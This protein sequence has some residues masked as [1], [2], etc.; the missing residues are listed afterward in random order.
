MS[1]LFSDFESVSAKQ[2]K[3]KIQYDLKGSDYNDTLVWQSLEG[4]HVAPTYHSDDFETFQPIIGTP[5][6]WNITQDIFIDD[7]IIANNLIHN[8][9]DKGAESVIL[10]AE[11]TFDIEKTFAKFPFG[12]IPIYLNFRFLD[13]DFLM[14]LSKF[15]SEKSATVFYNLDI[16]GNLAETGN[17]FINEDSDYA[18]LDNF[19]AKSKSKNIKTVVSVNV[20]LYQNAGA[21]MVQQLA[22][23]ICHANEYLNRL[24]T[25][26]DSGNISAEN[27][28]N[29]TINFDFAIGPNYFFEIAKI[30]ALR[31][32][33][34]ALAE[35]YN[36][37]PECHILARPSKR[38]KTIYDYNINMLR[39]TTECMSAALGGANAICNL[40]YDAL[41]HKSNDFGERIARNQ[42]IILKKES[43]FDTVTNAADGS[44]YIENLTTQLAEKAL[45]LFKD[46]EKSGGLLVQLKEGTIQK[47]IK[48]SAKKEQQFF[49]DGK[50]KLVGTNYHINETDLMKNDLQLY[51]FVKKNSRKTLIFPIVENRLAEK[52]EQERLKIEL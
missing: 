45:I 6:K 15:L 7:E 33:Y 44:Y 8:A 48:E 37:N 46:I 16:I 18:I 10:S 34:A 52:T 27:R 41:Y 21:N 42:L 3:Q 19:L 9:I 43:Y 40:P 14:D 11:K 1:T 25:L 26:N 38:N 23:A 24:D 30:R 51:P 22:Y 50:L 29:F 2:W 47:K 17:W 28:K 32:L 13:E 49:D 5:E 31:K 39:S 35:E 4:I 20:A 12:E 36:C